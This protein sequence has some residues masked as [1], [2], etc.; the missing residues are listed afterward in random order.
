MQPNPRD[1]LSS[2]VD[3]LSSRN[4]THMTDDFCFQR[5][6]VRWKQ[7]PEVS[8][9]RLVTV[10]ARG[11]R[12]Q[13]SHY[14]IPGPDVEALAFQAGLIVLD[15]NVLLDVYR[16]APD[17]RE[18]LLNVIEKLRDRIWIPHQVGE[19]FYRNRIS[20]MASLRTGYT[21][22]LKHIR[23]TKDEITTS[24]TE[25]INQLDNQVLLRD[26]KEDL[27]HRLEAALDPMIEAVEA[28]Q[29]RHNLPGSYS[30]DSI[31]ERVESLLEGRIGEPFGEEREEHLKEAQQRLEDERPPGY[32]DAKKKQ[33]SHGDYFVWR[34]VLDHAKEISSPVLLFV[35]QDKKEDWY[36]DVRGQSVSARP[37]LALEAREVAGCDVIMM[38]AAEFLRKSQE[39][40]HVTVSLETIREA[41]SLPQSRAARKLSA[42]LDE[43]A[44]TFQSRLVA[45]QNELELAA[46]TED[47]VDFIVVGYEERIH[48]IGAELSELTERLTRAE[49]HKTPDESR[50]IAHELARL[51]ASLDLIRRDHASASAEADRIK[52]ERARLEHEYAK[53]RYELAR[54]IDPMRRLS[55]MQQFLAGVDESNLA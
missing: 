25:K 30:Q 54:Q 21:F 46:H 52:N 37:E 13:F 18:E 45:L 41:E 55:P 22:L 48:G 11:F 7:Y 2:A 42:E 28:L 3:A 6:F 23:A 32:K 14:V 5:A 26:E 40:V 47:R 16:F 17:S 19:E 29:E 10:A 24:I 43:R 50:L 34:Q 1:L 8:E 51:S 4:T 27:L 44:I 35:T 12:D 9:S 31:L 49:I 15:T 53:L 39:Y 33:H 36:R 38:D 20:V